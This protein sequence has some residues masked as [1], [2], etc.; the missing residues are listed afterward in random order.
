MIAEKKLSEAR[1]QA[2]CVTWFKNTYRQYADL[3]HMNNNN[4]IGKKRGAI[5][6][7]MGLTAGVPDTFLALP[8]GKY[9]GFYIEFKKPGEKLSDEQAEVSFQL[10]KVGFHFAV[11]DNQPQFQYEIEKYLCL[12]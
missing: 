10:I 7:A 12:S 11:V 1:I 8:R 2:D 5:A 6:K 9:H 3:Y 4:S